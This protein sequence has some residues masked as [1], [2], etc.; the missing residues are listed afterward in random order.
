MKISHILLAALAGLG[1][2]LYPSKLGDAPR[3]IRNNNPLNIEENGTA[4]EGKAGDDGRFVVFSSPLYGIRAAARIL[5]TYASKYQLNTI[6][7]IVARWAPPVEN[8]TDNYI[9]FVSSKAGVDANAPLNDETYPAVIAAM[10]QMENGDNPYSID[11]IKQGF[12]W[13]FYG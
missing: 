5:R 1:F 7:G 12:A 6:S 11:D 4:W 9:N 13:G 3:G 10:I 2:V 8:D